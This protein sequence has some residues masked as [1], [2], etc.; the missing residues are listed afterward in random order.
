MEFLEFLLSPGSCCHFLIW[1]D[2]PDGGTRPCVFSLLRKRACGNDREL[3][4]S[5]QS[6]PM[7]FRGRIAGGGKTSEN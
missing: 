4:S 6:F 1:R 7:T 3:N 5:S 2:P